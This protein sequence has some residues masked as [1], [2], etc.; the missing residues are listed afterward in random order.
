MVDII[1]YVKQNLLNL[2]TILPGYDENLIRSVDDFNN[3]NTFW[4]CVDLSV[5][6]KKLVADLIFEEG[7]YDYEWICKAVSEVN[8]EKFISENQMS[9]INSV[10]NWLSENGVRTDEIS[11]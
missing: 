11:S 7:E 4:F 10:R 2:I 9:A 3:L 5:T 6:K 8:L 1:K